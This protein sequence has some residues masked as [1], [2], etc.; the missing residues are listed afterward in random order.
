MSEPDLRS[1]CIIV[2]TKCPHEGCSWIA[3]NLY[4]PTDDAAENEAEA[5]RIRKSAV[6]RYRGHARAAHGLAPRRKLQSNFTLPILAAAL[7][8]MKETS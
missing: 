1:A 5:A 8:A 2:R 6:G 4:V 7:A 3:G